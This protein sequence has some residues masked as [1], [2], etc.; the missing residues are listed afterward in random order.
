MCQDV[1][2][3][4]S[5][6]ELPLSISSLKVVP[7]GLSSTSLYSTGIQLQSASLSSVNPSE[8]E[9]SSARASSSANDYS[10]YKPLLSHFPETPKSEISATTSLIPTPGGSTGLG[11]SIRSSV[12]TF[13]SLEYSDDADLALTSGTVTTSLG[14]GE[15]ADTTAIVNPSETRSSVVHTGGV[16]SDHG[17][18]KPASKTPTV[19][20]P[21]N[22]LSPTGSGET[23]SAKTSSAISFSSNPSPSSTGH[24]LT[25]SIAIPENSAGS[26]FKPNALW[27]LLSSVFIFVLHA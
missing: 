19:V 2:E 4:S 5:T 25:S 26:N 11:L 10:T 3:G 8:I 7:L 17:G 15:T 6:T 23:G 16:S 1:H 22:S 12:V 18:G 27:L 21:S 20:I 14:P 13:T 9:S 24:R